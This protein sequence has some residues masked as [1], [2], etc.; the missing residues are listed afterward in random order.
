[1]KQTVLLIGIILCFFNGWSQIL[2][3]GTPYSINKQL[4]NE[5]EEVLMPSFDYE[6]LLKEDAKNMMKQAYRFAKVFPVNYTMEN[7]GTTHIDDAG[8]KIWRLK[9]SSQNAFSL[10]LIFRNFEIPDM[11]ELYIYTPDET[12]IFGAITSKNNKKDKILPTAHIPSDEIIVEYFEPKNVEFKG[13]FYI[14]DVSHNYRDDNKSEWCEININ[15]EEGGDWQ[16][17]KHSVCRYDFSIGSYE[18]WC[19]GA[20]VANTNNDNTPYFLTASHCINTQEMASTVTLYFNYESAT[21]DGTSGPENQTISNA[22]LIANKND[23]EGNLDFALLEM[24]SVPPIEYE[25]YYAGWNKYENFNATDVT[26]IH[27]PAGDIKKITKH[28]SGNNPSVYPYELLM[29]DITY[30]SHAHLYIWDWEEGTT[31]GGSSGS[32]LFSQNQRIIGD[33]SGG[34][35]ICNDGFDLY[36][37]FS[38]AWAKYSASDEQLKHWLDPTGQ[39]PTTY[40]GYYLYAPLNMIVNLTNNNVEILWDDAT[41]QGLIG[42][43]LYRNNSPIGSQLPNSQTSYTDNELENGEYTYCVK[44][45]YDSGNSPCSNEETVLIDNVNI[46]E[47]NAKEIKV[48]PN[49]ATNNITITNIQELS[50]LEIYNI[51]GIKLLDLNLNIN[52]NN[53]N[54]SNINSGIYFLKIISPDKTINKTLIINK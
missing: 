49:P 29:D 17:I 30:D 16:T 53:V 45:V 46:N 4:S 52:N 32:P 12:Y 9:I 18:Y 10:A 7:S 33:L 35:A 26:C 37:R 48:F 24:S 15:C 44:A 14:S 38:I 20:F 2:S 34:T 22:T 43:Q 21:C 36:Q 51:A 50:K 13:N 1:M 41:E 23:G 42:Y 25:A 28:N 19:T 27:H 47:F 54:I 11:S 6:A 5:I 40:D 3:E 31:E 39:N 8:N